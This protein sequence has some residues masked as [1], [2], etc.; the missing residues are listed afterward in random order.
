M[1]DIQENTKKDIPNFCNV[2][3]EP[4]YINSYCNKWSHFQS[5]GPP[6]GA[7]D[8]AMECARVRS[9]IPKIGPNLKKGF[10]D[11]QRDKI[12]FIHHHLI[13]V[14]ENRQTIITHEKEFA[15]AK[16]LFELAKRKY[17]QGTKACCANIADHTKMLEVAEEAFKKGL[18]MW[19]TINETNTEEVSQELQIEEQLGREE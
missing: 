7:S 16:N 15:L 3:E 12:R 13:A 18:N 10:T 9:P 11:R 4:I 2:C 17:E 5:E 8:I 1:A 14:E 6:K 19:P